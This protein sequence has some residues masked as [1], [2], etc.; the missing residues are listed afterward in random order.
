M[1]E[2]IKSFLFKN[3]SDKQTVAKNTV[4]LSISNFGGRLI[5]AAIVIYGARALGTA[6]YG[7]FSYAV[8][9][10]GFFTLFVD[11]GVNAILVREG[12]KAT[13]AERRA[14]FSTT[15][16]IKFLLLLISI[17]VV[18]FIAPSFSTLPGAV[19]LLPIVAIMIAGDGLR[20]FF[21]SLMRATEHMEW[22]AATFLLETIAIVAFGFLF[23]HFSPTPLAFTWAYAVGT[24][25]GGLSAGILVRHYFKKIK[26]YFSWSLVSKVA[27]AAWPFAVMTSLGA[28][29]T[30]TD[31]LMISWMKTAAD[32]G[33]YSAAIRI[34]QVLYV[35]P[36]IIQ[37]T[38][39]PILSRLAKNDPN[40]FRSVLE[41]TVS[42]IL[43]VAWPV[44]LGGI[45]LA[46]PI[47][48]L[49]FGPAYAAG[50]VAFAIL[51]G[52]LLFDYAGSTIS[53][54]VFAYNHQKN[55]IIASAIG[56]CSNVAFDLLFIPH[57]G[58]VGSAIATLIA[59]IAGNS[60]LWH[61]MDRVNHFSVIPKLGKIALAGIVMA[62]ACLLFMLSHMNVV[63]N[64]ALCGALYLLLLKIFQEPMLDEIKNVL[65][66]K[67]PNIEIEGI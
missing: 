16:V 6:G 36:L 48:T 54:A 67:N 33:I 13:D 49:I 55:L 35:V 29:L 40:K 39:L 30:N 1:F 17:V 31:I 12:S 43:L 11:P 7:L 25:I 59:Q 60:Y 45:V 42:L 65:A 64:I 53:N 19:I 26:S 5:K 15:L 51:L 46:M 57:W 37:Y 58:I 21:A 52:S 27:G 9:L 20:E 47:M 62:C 34:V 24:A 10:A 44:S 63:L 4:W 8:T 18:I 41:R 2:K 32:V 66:M 61:T 38:T 23:L 28:L 3:T 50:S 22:D 56:A 14:L